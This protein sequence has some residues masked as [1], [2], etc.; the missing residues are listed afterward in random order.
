MPLPLPQSSTNSG[1]KSVGRKRR[2][3]NIS[4]FESKTFT[5]CS[6]W[7][8]LQ[9][10][11]SVVS[12]LFGIPVDGIVLLALEWILVDTHKKG[13]FTFSKYAKAH[14]RIESSRNVKL[15]HVHKT[16]ANLLVRCERCASGCKAY[17]SEEVQDKPTNVVHC[18]REIALDSGAH[19]N[20]IQATCSAITKP[21]L[22]GRV[23]SR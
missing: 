17:V 18:H 3:S 12:S 1:V 13:P 5:T 16:P 6:H 7:I 2:L 19:F 8:A 14:A 21:G 4:F 23:R 11:G 15:T 10:R 20:M 22:P 9:R